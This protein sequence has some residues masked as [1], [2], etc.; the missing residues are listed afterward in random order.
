MSDTLWAAKLHLASGKPATLLGTDTIRDI[1]EAYVAAEEELDRWRNP[2]SWIPEARFIPK[3]ASDC[4]D[5]NCDRRCMVTK[6]TP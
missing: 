4:K 6:V 3:H 2:V 1:C 5:S